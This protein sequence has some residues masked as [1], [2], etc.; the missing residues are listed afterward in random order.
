MNRQ[1]VHPDIVNVLIEAIQT[2]EEQAISFRDYMEICLYNE[3]NG[4]Y[5]NANPKIG[6]KGD[7][8]TSSS[9]G[10]VMGEM[11]AAFICKEINAQ[12]SSADEKGP[13]HIVEWGGGNGSLA[14]HLIDEIQRSA[15]EVY[16]RLIYTIIES[17]S[18][19]RNQQQAKL[20]G[21][22][23]RIR[24]LNDTMWFAEQAV[25]QIYVLANELLDAFP[26]HR[27]RYEAGQ[28]HESYVVWQGETQCFQ[29]I[30]L[31]IRSERILDFLDRTEVQWMNG[32]I[33]E[34]NLEAEVWMG[35][36]AG[37]ILSGSC[38]I[39]DYGD[40]EEELY[41]AHRQLG[42]LMCYRNH[43]AGDNPFVYQGEQDITAHVNFTGCQDAA[44]NHGFTVCKLQ[45]QREFLVE[46]GILQKLQDHY[47]PN[48]FSEVSKRNRA[49]RQLLLSDQMSELFKVC[50][51][52]KK[53]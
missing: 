28:F 21:H 30:W 14:L 19:H 39:I 29:E 47:D 40:V 27:I 36:I 34:L 6:K 48:P 42:T 22:V 25:E 1:L 5:R 33:A 12:I 41:A 31:P 7:F 4:Y 32:Q 51:A 52:T 44:I 8:Y 18:Y 45:T 46:Q 50:I 15:P 35:Q 53:R 20:E 23:D 13:V 16:E 3:P 24:F 43:Q 49:I 37:Q 38:L 17:S 10:T 11:V 9:I 2:K 26:V